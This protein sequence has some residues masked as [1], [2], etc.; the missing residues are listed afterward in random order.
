[1]VKKKVVA[2]M[3]AA[4][5]VASY[6]PITKVFAGNL[7][8]VNGEKLNLEQI[9]S[10]AIKLYKNQK[11]QE[12][13]EKSDL[14][15]VET[16]KTYEDSDNVRV[17][18]TLE[19]GN[20]L[21]RSGI[22]EENFEI[23]ALTLDEM[24][25]SDIGF[26]VRYQFTE[27]VNTITGDVK[28]GDIKKIESL[29]NV[30]SVR[31]AREYY[32]DLANSNNM[33][34][35]QQVWDEYGYKGEGM[36][37]AVL[38]TGFQVNHPDFLLGEEGS[39]KA[40]LTEENLNNV[41]DST[42]VDDIYY[43]EK[44]PTGYDW[45]N[46]DNDISPAD[47]FN[48]SHGMHVAGI[49]GAN[50]DV[51]NGGVKG[52][53]PEVQIVG[54]KVFADDGRG[55]E[56]D[57]IA[58]INH[59]VEVGADVINMSLGSDAGFVL[60]DSD[61]MQIAIENASKAGVL[62]VVA[63]GNAYYST[64]DLYSYRPSSYADNF[65]IGTVGD[66]SI[67][68]YALSVASMNNNKI[69][70]NVAELSNGEKIEYLNQVRFYPILTEVIGQEEYEV[71][72][73]NGTN[74]KDF[75][76]VDCKGKVVLLE[77]DN[78][79]F[80][81][82]SLQVIA[83]R[84]GAVA[85]IVSGEYTNGY[86]IDSYY[87]V[88]VASTN[89]E[90]G[91]KIS[92]LLEDGEKLS[93][94]FTNKVTVVPS[95]DGVE[96]SDFSGWGTTST[97]DFKPEVSGVGGDIY[98]TTPDSQHT[99]M[100]G[101]SM[102]SPQVAGAVAI[103][104]QSMKEKNNN[105]DFETVMTAKNILMNNTEIVE[106]ISADAPYS[107]RKQGAGLIQLGNALTTPIVV[108]DADAEVQKR[109]AVAL[110]EVEN[111]FEFNLGIESFADEDLKFEVIVDL[112]TD[113]RD[114]EDVDINLDGEVDFNKEVTKLTSRK[115]NGA[116]ITINGEAVSENKYVTVDG[117]TTLN[118]DVNLS[119][120]DI[121]D[122]SYVEGFVRFI[123]Q[124][125]SYDE[126]SIPLMGF[127]G[128][129]NDA[130]NVDE[131]M[132]GGEPYAEYTAIFSYDSDTP[133]GFSRDTATINEDKIAFSPKGYENLIGPKFTVLRNLEYLNVS[134]EDENGNFVKELYEDEYVTKNT[135][136]NRNIF[137]SIA[138]NNPWDG[139]NEENVLVED[140]L[141]TF[142]IKSKF[143]YEGSEI[144]ETKMNVKVDATD[145]KV[146]D[147]KITEVDGGYE[148]TFDVYD[149]TSG[150]N[151]SILFID[152]EYVPLSTGE[153]SHFVEEMP[154]ELVVVAFDNA[155][156]AGIG[157]YGDS[158]EIDAETMLLYFHVAGDYVNYEN[159]C[160]IYGAVQKSLT[161]KLSIVGPTG[162]VVYELEDFESSL[163]STQFLPEQGE[164][165]G[166]Y[167][168]TGYLLDKPTGI[169]ANLDK[170]EI[171]IEDNEV[172]DKSELFNVIMS[173]K[174]FR[175][176][177]L[178]GTE[179]GQYPEEAVNEFSDTLEGVID[180]YYDPASTDEDISNAIEVINN[181]KVIL[182]DKVNP[183]DG[184]VSAIKLLEYSNGLVNKAVIGDRPGNYTEASVE[185]LKTAISELQ[186]LVDSEEEITDEM[187]NEEIVKLNNEIKVFLE[188][189]IP[190]GDVSKIESLINDQ[191]L[192]I[193][194]VKNAET[195]KKYEKEVVEAYEALLNEYA[196]SIVES[197]TID[198]AEAKFEEL[199][200][201]VEAFSAS[202]IDISGLKQT[203]D[204]ANKIL[205]EIES[206]ES[207][208]DSEAIEELKSFIEAGENIVKA[209]YTSE[210]EVSK[211][212]SNIKAAIKNVKDSKEDV[213][214][215]VEPSN[216]IDPSNPG[217]SDNDKEKP[218]DTN[219]YIKG[220]YL[221]NSNLPKTGAVVGSTVVVGIGLAAIGAGSI[222]LKKKRK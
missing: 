2:V 167:T 45:A 208:Y 133:L 108:Y 82:L 184:K 13:N 145:P 79:Y 163:F 129:W 91:D 73:V 42:E 211:A 80:V 132:V 19:E 96:A 221:D 27:D 26:D 181:A 1:M 100:S 130:A 173:M 143:A 65:D 201:D 81:N 106:E 112:Y 202:A 29:D 128:D 166:S 168:L 205:I 177:L 158:K 196:D 191:R 206:E 194:L 22:S 150:Y 180:I 31:V 35:A 20:G 152:N 18:V 200:S 161:W 86:N 63:A 212:I 87:K 153:K 137:Y 188:S 92:K 102:A 218:G 131:P 30:V 50:G 72:K 220:D 123:P 114:T 110:K 76:D 157:V 58:G 198:E 47:P 84:Y 83:N 136:Y 164:P 149:E 12:K 141:Y 88:P 190:A 109:S 193:E 77:V 116:N 37:V 113:E 222:L 33:V 15:N 60:E 69:T 51:E 197:L 219:T 36:V 74:E 10:E 140:G 183:S 179:A 182:E 127:Y 160:Y 23:Q 38:D 185:A 186:V 21:T 5:L 209:P 7:A 192:F 162:D 9:K 172:Y 16:S 134:V 146:S 75:K 189:V 94:K 217:D 215:P 43:N 93:I 17:I 121:L 103:L 151:G 98:S 122:K 66:P 104:L 41:L 107:P 70:A 32:V 159:T 156:N 176:N 171:N 71:V 147:I 195:E 97:L 49:V 115:V 4:I 56:D 170:Y 52:I 59:A 214:K 28:Y 105:L 53:A 99:T 8:T 175:D 199:K 165:N 144:Q 117:A 24:E 62:V 46:K 57:I 64:K 120:S 216:P 95:V 111:D 126:V 135:F 40:K 54:E 78:P 125:S 124:N 138:D 142:V 11:L 25:S 14:Y 6:L 89:K 61:L 169:F 67:S 48:A 39:E 213:I 90:N 178:V 154:S 187:F 207:L 155:K 174:E 203:I 68:S 101:T 34:Q 210:E 139:T 85:I 118:V 148:I 3:L 119:N 55:Y 204:N 44:F